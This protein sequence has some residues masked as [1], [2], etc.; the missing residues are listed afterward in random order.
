MLTELITE[1]KRAREHGFTERELDL[2]RRQLLA[3][4]ERAVRTE[5]TLNAQ[6][7]IS[8]IVASVNDRTPQLSAQTSLD[9]YEEHLPG[10]TLDEVNRAFKEHFKPGAFAHI[11]T[12]VEKEGVHVPSRDEVLGSARKAWDRDVEPLPD[13]D[14]ATEL[15]DELPE[16]GEL[17]EQSMDEEL[18]VTSA[19]LDNGVRMHHRFMD[20]KKDSVYVS[21]SLAGGNIEETAA[22]AGI[23]QVATLAVNEAATSRLSSSEMRDLM[24]GKNINVGAAPAGDSLLITISGSPLDLEAGLQKAHALILDGHIEDSAFR[25]WKLQILQQ[26]QERETLPHFKAY[27]AVEQILSNND[28]RRVPFRK[29]NVE[30][31]TREAAQAWYD[32]LCAKAPIEVA[33]VGDLPADR[34]MELVA[35]YL[36]SL[37][38][39]PRGAGHLKPLRESKREEGPH[40]RTV[41]VSTV[42]PQAVAIAGFAGVEGRNTREAR[43]LQLAEQI[44]SSRLVKRVREDL[45]IVYSIFARNDPSWI[46]E[47]AGRFQAGAPCDPGN[48]RKV[49]DEVHKLYTEFAENGPSDEELT[50][51]KKQVANLLDTSMREPTYWWSILRHHDLH[52]R[53]LD[54]ENS[55]LEDYEELTAEAVRETFGKYYT[56]ARKYSVIATPEPKGVS[57]HN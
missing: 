54:A 49:I 13:S 36:G 10:V 52:D 4:A 14:A 25:N 24:T 23:T 35:R 50:N 34:A 26:L 1:V 22:N 21:I 41:E 53:D 31:I 27:E 45:S 29:E 56:A 38:E 32:R 5:P 6:S 3:A 57:P 16:P 48:A 51:A 17:V 11:V 33:V 46:Y 47:D 2:A 28:P 39:R 18:G 37:P 44:L 15:L 12:L 20:Y 7:I 19:W 40:T 9:L 42:T 43:A 8:Q 30:A 55:I